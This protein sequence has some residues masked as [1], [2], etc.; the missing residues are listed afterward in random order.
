M[1]IVAPVEKRNRVRE[2]LLRLALSRLE[3]LAKVKFL[4]YEAV[5]DISTGSSPVPAAA[6]PWR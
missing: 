4:P 3:L 2:Q 1:F 5:D 6:P